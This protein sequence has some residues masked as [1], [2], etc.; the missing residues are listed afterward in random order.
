MKKFLSFLFLIILWT[1]TSN[2]FEEGQNV[3]LNACGSDP[4]KYF[5][6]PLI[7]NNILLEAPNKIIK[8]EA[9]KYDREFQTLAKSTIN[10]SSKKITINLSNFRD[11][12]ITDEKGNTLEDRRVSGATSIYEI[13]HQGKVAA[14]G[15]GWHKHCKESYPHVDFTAFR[16]FVPYLDSGGVKIQNKFVKLKIKQVEDALIDSDKLILADGID[17]N[18]NSSA[19]TY[20]YHGASFFEVDNQNGINF[21][22]EFEELN[23]KIDINKLNPALI[24]STLAKY[25]EVE[26]LNN[27][28][29]NNFDKIYEDLSSNYWWDVWDGYFL[30]KID[31]PNE[32][33]NNFKE[34]LKRLEITY[35]KIDKLQE[36]KLYY[37]VPKDEVEVVKKNC[38]SNDSYKDIFELIGNCYPWHSSWMV[39]SIGGEPNY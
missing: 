5:N 24:L 34:I 7:I 19:S 13:K 21:D 3:Y 6:S 2:A 27:Y 30:I 22:L 1:N 25:K 29:K 11:L 10:L 28:T 32:I 16:L 35:E 20:Y 4:N 31:N 18:G 12:V 37:A 8:L 26:K 39:H 9:S 23:K 36:A 17:I 14:W 15:V 38:F 33:N